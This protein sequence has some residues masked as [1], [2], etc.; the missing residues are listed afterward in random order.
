LRQSAPQGDALGQVAGSWGG[1]LEQCWSGLLGAPW[2]LAGDMF[3]DVEKVWP[4]GGYQETPFTLDAPDAPDAKSY[5]A[6]PWSDYKCVGLIGDFFLKASTIVN[7][8]SSARVTDCLG[9]AQS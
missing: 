5:P 6:R 2:E 9:G 1:G 7:G 4:I 3:V 8:I